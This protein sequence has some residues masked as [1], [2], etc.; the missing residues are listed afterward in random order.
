VNERSY[1]DVTEAVGSE[2]EAEVGVAGVVEGFAKVGETLAEELGV[3]TFLLS[4]SDGCG[5]I[6]SRH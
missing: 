3:D 2:V 5:V 4:L 6:S 1:V